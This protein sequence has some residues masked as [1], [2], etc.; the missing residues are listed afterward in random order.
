M[1]N[2]SLTKKTSDEPPSEHLADSSIHFVHRPAIIFVVINARLDK[3]FVTRCQK[4]PI[5]CHTFEGSHVLMPPMEAQRRCNRLYRVS[6]HREIH[7]GLNHFFQIDAE[8]YQ[9]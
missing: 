8:L 5:L 2:L 3:Q 1:P 7:L 9:P 6:W 4:I